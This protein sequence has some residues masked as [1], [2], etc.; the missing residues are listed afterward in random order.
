MRR[1]FWFR[2]ELSRKYVLLIRPRPYKDYLEIIA[3]F[4]F[5]LFFVEVYNREYFVEVSD[6]LED[7]H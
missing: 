2:L 4:Y 7:L 5:L 6:S 1:T 3:F